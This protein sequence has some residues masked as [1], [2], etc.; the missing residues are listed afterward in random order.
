MFLVGASINAADSF[1]PLFLQALGG[2]AALFSFSIAISTMS[3]PPIARYGS[4][5]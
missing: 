2:G 5:G 1:F 3:E 4:P